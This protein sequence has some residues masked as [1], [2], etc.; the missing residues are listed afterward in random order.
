MNLT[1]NQN[2]ALNSLHMLLRLSKVRVTRTTLRNKLRQHPA[3]PNLTSL[4]DTLT[5]LRVGNLAVDISPEQLTK[6]PLPALAY[7]SSEGGFFA[8]V[9]AATA[10]SVE[11]WHHQKGW[12][13]E[14]TRYFNRH[15]NGVA[16]L[17]E[18]TDQ[19]G[20]KQYAQTQRREWAERLRLP[21]ALLG[22]L[23]CLA[24]WANRYHLLTSS[25]SLYNV[26]LLLKLTGLCLS[27][28]LVWYS[29]DANNAFL[30]SLCQLNSHTNCGAVLSTSAAYLVAGLSWAEVGLFYFSGGL[31]SLLLLHASPSALYPLLFG[32]TLAA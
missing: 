28:L 24:V 8:P 10:D 31:L 22:L 16:L 23:V 2:R 26:L 27:S 21:L 20:E 13:Q 9:R 30:R 32:T 5:D 6:I 3:F 15:W 1:A 4:S 7:L 29:F 19:S 14:S 17:I 25:A 12:Q 11:W 18:P